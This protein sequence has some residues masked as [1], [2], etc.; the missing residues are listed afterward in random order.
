MFKNITNLEP[1]N[2]TSNLSKT[3]SQ[4]DLKQYKYDVA[5][6]KAALSYAELSYAERRKVAALLVKDNRPLCCGFNGTSPGQNNVCEDE[7]TCNECNG[8]GYINAPQEL[9][10]KLQSS[11]I[12]IKS[13][14]GINAVKFMC[15]SYMTYG[16]ILKTKDE[17]HHAERNLLGYANRYGIP[18][19]GCTIYITLSPCVDCAKQMEIAVIS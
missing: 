8:V 2:N 9:L 10:N 17:V 13:I 3:L 15:H 4:S 7:V 18:T 6:M 16:K 11:D 12:L 19:E 14:A 5:H 1:T